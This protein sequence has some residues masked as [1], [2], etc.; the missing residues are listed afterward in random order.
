MFAT[1]IELSLPNQL[2][3]LVW[4]LGLGAGV[5]AGVEQAQRRVHMH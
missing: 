4:P 3:A 5:G 2:D 1:P